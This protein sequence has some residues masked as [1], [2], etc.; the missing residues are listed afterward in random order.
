[1]EGPF[2]DV[3]PALGGLAGNGQGGEEHEDVF[4]GGHEPAVVVAGVANLGSVVFVFHFD[5]DGEPL[6]A[7]GGLVFARPPDPP[8]QNSLDF[9]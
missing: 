6:A 8:S 2:E 9:C 1:M 5:V 7:D 4:F 3:E